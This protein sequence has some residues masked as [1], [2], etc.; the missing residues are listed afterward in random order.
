MDR[1]A[2][3]WSRTLAIITL[4]FAQVGCDTQGELDELVRAIAQRDPILAA[5][6]A[7]GGPWIYN[8]AADAFAKAPQLMLESVPISTYGGAAGDPRFDL[9]RVDYV[10]P[11]S[12]GRLMSF[13][14]VGNHVFVFGRDGKGQRVIGRTG[15][16][17][18]DWMRFGNPVP[19]GGD[20]VLV[21]DFANN[22][23]NWVTADGGVVRTAPFEVGGDTRRMNSIA[24][25]VGSRELVM[26]TA[27]FW[28]G[29]DRDSLN[30][31]LARVASVNIGTGRFRDLFTIPDLQGVEFETRFRGRV[32][33]EWMW[34][35]LG[36][37][38]AV[39]V[40]DSQVA[41]AI[42]TSP[43]IELRDAQGNLRGRMRP[44]AI[45]RAVTRAMRDARI[46]MELGWINAP[47]EQMVDANESR[48]VAR[49]SPFADSLP[50]YDRLIAGSDQTL[51][52]V[53]A[54]ALSDNGW[55]ATGYTRD[56]SIRARVTAKGRSRPMSFGAGEVVV[57]SEDEN[58]V[59]TLKRY[60]LVPY[61]R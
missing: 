14:R 54:I 4:T 8:Y 9:T 49:E 25:F 5:A 59:V 28:G 31:S 1:I 44:P 60:R 13:A 17:P 16:G 3:T 30:R 46:E 27:G 33:R 2:R 10:V 50:Y 32:A 19:V 42:A 34:L 47:T 39:A 48:R 52:A 58:G 36:G 41:S 24:G 35:R 15:Q 61:R 45:R 43:D 7:Q 20:S 55:T 11:L 18:G 23:L 53:D 12:D 29:H 22:R 6:P 40:W 57:R 21:V 26:H 51:W 38:S 37:S 56:G